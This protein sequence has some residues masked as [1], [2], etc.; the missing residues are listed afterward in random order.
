[1]AFDFKFASVITDPAGIETTAYLFGAQSPTDPTPKAYSVQALVDGVMSINDRGEWTSGGVF[2]RNDGVLVSGIGPGTGYFVSMSSFPLTGDLTS[3]AILANQG[4]LWRRVGPAWSAPNG[5]PSLNAMTLNQVGGGSHIRFQRD[6]LTDGFIRTT[7]NG[8]FQIR[9]S[10][11]E[12]GVSLISTV[13]TQAWAPGQAVLANDFRRNAGIVYRAVNSATTGTTPPTHTTGSVSDG[14]VTWLA[15]PTAR[16]QIAG[17][18]NFPTITLVAGQGGTTSAPI[19]LDALGDAGVVYL[20][21]GALYVQNSAATPPAIKFALM[22]NYTVRGFVTAASGISFGVRSAAVSGTNAFEVQNAAA[23]DSTLALEPR[24][25]GLGPRLLT[26]G[27]TNLTF[28]PGGLNVF[29]KNVQLTAATPTITTSGTTNL[30]ITPGGDA[31][32]IG[33]NLRLR[34]STFAARPLSGNAS[35]DLIFITNGRKGGEGAGSGTGVI[36]QWQA[37]AT[38]WVLLNTTT[39]V[40]A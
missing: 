39:V 40:T 37:G 12:P 1:M 33:K 36:A 25:S 8:L 34:Q 26:S 7:F 31:L 18:S 29:E 15:E 35:G 27:S 6:G 38:D 19:A 5:G 17:N 21:R 30:T 3:P 20:G 32:I 2:L 11:D 13:V 14:A 22:D 9:N 24:G 10:F 28:N 4:T 16:V 23:Y